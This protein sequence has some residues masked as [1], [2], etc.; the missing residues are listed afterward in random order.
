M[1]RVTREFTGHTLN[2]K[3]GSRPVKPGLRRFNQ[4]KHQ[5]MGKELSRILATGFVKEVQHSDW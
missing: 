1:S 3:L 4:E 2:I 5:D